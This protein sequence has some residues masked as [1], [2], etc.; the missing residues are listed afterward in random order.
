[1]VTVHLYG[2]RV[3]IMTDEKYITSMSAYINHVK[4][5]P[6]STI[7]QN[8]LCCIEAKKLA[9]HRL[10]LF[11]SPSSAHPPI[12]PRFAIDKNEANYYNNGYV[13]G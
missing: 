13:Y 6:T 1:M 12:H 2:G 9:F 7:G 11:H 3:M 5:I 4:A 8:Y 10:H